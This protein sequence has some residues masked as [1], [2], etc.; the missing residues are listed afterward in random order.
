M[1][2]IVGMALGKRPVKN[3][4]KKSQKT[5]ANFLLASSSTSLLNQGSGRQTPNRVRSNTKDQVDKPEDL[6]KT[7]ASKVSS[8]FRKDTKAIIWGLQNRAVQ[9]MLDFDFVCDRK[10]PSVVASV[11]PF[12]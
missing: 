8:L 6:L 5:T 7:A 4:Q 11:Y 12:V 3:D 2:A 10:E 1:T 9:G